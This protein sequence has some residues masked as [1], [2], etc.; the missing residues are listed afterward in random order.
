MTMKMHQEKLATKRGEKLEVVDI[1]E[2]LS[3]VSE[4]LDPRL[5]LRSGVIESAE[6]DITDEKMENMNVFL[7]TKYKLKFKSGDLKS[8]IRS[9]AENNSYDPVIQYLNR[10]SQTAEQILNE[11]EWA[12]VARLTLGLEGDYEREV[13]QK[14]LIAAARRAL[15]PG[16]K[17]DFA[18]VLKGKQGSAKSTF[19][20]HLG[21]EWFTDSLK[22][23]NNIKDDL[24][25]MN[26]NWICEWSEIDKVFRGRD[27]SEEVK[28]FVS[29]RHD[30]YRAP[31]ARSAKKVQRNSIL[32]GTTNRD[33]WANDPT[34]NRRYPI[35]ETKSANHEWTKENRDRIW[36]RAAVEARKG[37]PHHFS[38]EQEAEISLRAL[39]FSKEDTDLPYCLETLKSEA[40]RWFSVKEL[41]CIAL[42]WDPSE[43]EKR[44]FEALGT[45]LE[46]LVRQGCLRERRNHEPLNRK[47]G[48]R[49]KLIC[50]CYPSIEAAEAL[51]K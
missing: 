48:L 30:T 42:D 9:T 25:T 49:S 15:E 14:F 6:G 34:G 51:N 26:S 36:G 11:G 21:G 41:A 4:L 50:Y 22:G 29:A 35:L 20:D 38:P 3:T 37:T 2:Y 13:V 27:K 7:A 46:A 24:M 18:L 31:Y 8:S 44:R 28:A 12:D 40:G 10:C 45:R 5:N 1:T 32:C 47:Y 17:V 39:D 33:D 19:F 16:C 43:T 23:L